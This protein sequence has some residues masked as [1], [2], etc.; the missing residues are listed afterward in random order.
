MICG[1]AVACTNIDGYSIMAKQEDTALLSAPGDF[2]ALADNIARLIA[3][4]ELRY[5]IAENGH[6]NIQ[7]YRWDDS[8]LYFKKSVERN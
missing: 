1:A 6:K 7:K 2:K 4:D 5:K 8:Y 3:N